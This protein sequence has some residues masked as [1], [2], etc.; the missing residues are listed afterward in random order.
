MDINGYWW[1]LTGMNGGWT[2]SL[3]VSCFIP[4]TAWQTQRCGAPFCSAGGFFISA[5]KSMFFLEWTLLWRTWVLASH[6]PHEHTSL[7][8]TYDYADTVHENKLALVMK[9]ASAQMPA[10]TV[11]CRW[12]RMQ[13]QHACRLRSWYLIQRAVW[14]TTVCCIHDSNSP[15]ECVHESHSNCQ[16]WLTKL[17]A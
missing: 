8:T 10:A 6:R 9:S 13:M 12:L 1:I 2:L 4:Q 3:D 5:A 11:L 16:V 17:N 7:Q 14:G 15:G